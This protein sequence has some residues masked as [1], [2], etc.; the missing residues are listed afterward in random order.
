MAHTTFGKDPNGNPYTVELGANWVSNQT[1][2]LKLL[3][4]MSR[5]KD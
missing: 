2:I 4:S 5:S 1:S 3:L